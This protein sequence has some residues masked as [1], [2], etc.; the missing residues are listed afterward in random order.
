MKPTPTD[1]TYMSDHDQTP[2]SVNQLPATVWHDHMKT[3]T[4]LETD[5]GQNWLHLQMA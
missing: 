1:K 4:P 5:M 2:I 3:S